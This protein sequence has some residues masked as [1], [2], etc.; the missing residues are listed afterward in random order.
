M[1]VDD[2]GPHKKAWAS[3]GPRG[4]RTTSRCLGAAKTE[5]IFGELVNAVPKDPLCG[6]QNAAIK[7]RASLLDSNFALRLLYYEIN[8]TRTAPSDPILISCV[9]FYQQLLK[10]RLELAGSMYTFSEVLQIYTF[11]YPNCMYDLTDRFL[12]TRGISSV[13]RRPNHSQSSSFKE[14]PDQMPS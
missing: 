10:D 5:H 4:R 1:A 8:K 13:I 14:L 7:P 9:N 3:T 2:P 12:Q 6:L 11:P